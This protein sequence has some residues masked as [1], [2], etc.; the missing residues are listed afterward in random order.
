MLY[1]MTETKE[2]VPVIDEATCS[3]SQLPESDERLARTIFVGNV[4]LDAK[5]EKLVKFFKPCG[6]IESIRF[7]SIPVK[8]FK[9][10]KRAAVLSGERLPERDSMNAYIVFQSEESV[11]AALSL[12][13]SLFQSKHLKIDRAERPTVSPGHSIFVGNLPFD[14]EDEELYQVFSKLGTIRYVR[15]I[16]DKVTGLGKGFGYVCFNE[17]IAVIAAVR[18]NGSIKVKDRLVRIFRCKN[19]E[20]L[21]KRQMSQK[22]S[23]TNRQQPRKKKKQRTKKTERPIKKP[24]Q[25][26]HKKKNKMRKKKDKV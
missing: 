5:R 25:K 15:I 4:P 21:K 16:R 6:P 24:K 18:K 1:T 7:R 9:L 14:A 26:V 3:K 2:N 22:S 11:P 8:K 12:S 13:G 10:P 20:K 17:S 23:T 19:S